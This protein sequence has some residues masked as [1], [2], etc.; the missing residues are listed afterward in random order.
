[1]AIHTIEEAENSLEII[2]NFLGT[3]LIEQID[4]FLSEQPFPEE[5]QI[6]QR[7]G[8]ISI[9]NSSIFLHYQGNT[10]QVILQLKEK[11]AQ[12]LIKGML[13][14]N[15]IKERLKNNREINVPDWYV[16]GLAKYVAHPKV[17]NSSWMADYY[18][19]KL[20][21]NLNLTN[22]H[23]LAAFGHSVFCY[24]NDSFGMN[25]LRQILFYTKLS[26]KTD[27]AFQFVL[28]KSLN[29]LIADWFKL[30]KAKYLEETTSRLPNDPEPINEKLKSANILQLKFA[31]D[32]TQL[33]FLIQTID[34]IELWNYNILNQK[35][36]KIYHTYFKSKE[37]KWRFVRSAQSYF[38]TESNGISSTLT[39][40]NQ[41]LKPKKFALDFNYILELK[42]HPENGIAILAQKNYRI[43]IIQLK[44]DVGLNL[45]NL[46]NSSLE[47]TDFVFD[48]NN[49][50]L[51][52]SFEHSKIRI[53]KADDSR[54][55]FQSDVPISFL[56]SY[57]DDFISFIQCTPDKNIGRIVNLN[58]SSEN[59]LVTNYTRSI[60]VYDYNKRTKKVLEGIK[61]GHSNYV[62]ISVAS[63]DAIN[64]NLAKEIS[65][66]KNHERKEILDSI[67]EV[68][69]LYQFITG[70]EYKIK[71]IPKPQL[72]VGVEPKK[73]FKIK[74]YTAENRELKA[75]NIRL[76]FSNAQFHSPSFAYFWP[77]PA[78]INNGPNLIIGCTIQDIYKKY[79][80]SSS[81]RQP[82]IGKGADFNLDF[83][84]SLGLKV[85]GLSL[86]NANYQSELYNQANKYSMRQLSATFE[87]QG[88]PRLT[89][90]GEAG[91]R[92]DL[93]IPLYLNS[94]LQNLNPI[95]LRNPFIKGYLQ[96]K[97]SFRPQLNYSQ[98]ITTHFSASINKPIGKN[99]VNTNLHLTLNHDQT[100]FRIIHIATKVSMQTSVG[101]Q[102]TVWLVGGV[103]NWLRPSFGNSSRFDLDRIN[104]YS[105]TFDFEGLPY[106]FK[107]G[108]SVALCKINLTLPLNP[109]LSQQNFNQNIFKYLSLRS[110]MNFGLPWFGKNPYSIHNPENK[111][112]IET[113]SMSIVNYEAKNPMIWSWGIGVNSII[114]GYETS[115][116]YAVGHHLNQR[117]GSLLHLTLGKSF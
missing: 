45:V 50:L 104:M 6:Q 113:G 4:I 105:T 26:G 60:A 7:N 100:L 77:I 38:L 95:K 21:L 25:K 83:K 59:V 92:E 23:E 43:D 9:D 79:L 81:I 71:K 110:Y 58:D 44:F 116:D 68:K 65:G 115:I 27:Y 41:G 99:G 74:E 106:N 93:K 54:V 112:V 88:N 32:G 10:Q 70:F 62:V 31:I 40:L 15:T 66:D 55:F 98:K 97:Y 18:E 69:F 80:L 1:M 39:K 28:N 52:S 86:F 20:N 22:E 103:A 91:Y 34:E 5:E 73:Q 51:I 24:I 89:L 19:G 72:N 29:W 117:I 101:K 107:A 85:L 57:L 8:L 13:Y 109:I 11:L 96:H 30:E 87:I 46:T 76:G 47:E 16:S 84:H 61:Y 49:S 53:S 12:I 3:R 108:T 75:A 64:H 33:D 37:N 67:P 94:E 14:G 63:L 35:S 102:K 42:N 111:D 82:L 36:T 78:G 56:S 17:A 48:A 114:F 2:E 90:N